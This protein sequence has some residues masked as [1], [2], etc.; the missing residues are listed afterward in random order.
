MQ[1]L[2]ILVVLIR[3]LPSLF[4][5]LLL[6]PHNLFQVIPQVFSS[7]LL[8]FPLKSILHLD[9]WVLL[10]PD[11]SILMVHCIEFFIF[12]QVELEVVFLL[13]E[14]VEYPGDQT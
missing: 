1:L 2:I 10:C 13:E 8:R 11:A 4:L 6:V 12:M 14:V 7:L 9:Q 5:L 3:R